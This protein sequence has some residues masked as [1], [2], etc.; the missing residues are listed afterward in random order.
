MVES[1]DRECHNRQPLREFFPAIKLPEIGVSEAKLA[2]SKGEVL[3]ELGADIAAHQIGLAYTRCCRR[4]IRDAR[5]L[6]HPPSLVSR[7]IDQATLTGVDWTHARGLD[8]AC[9]GELSL[10]PVARRIIDEL[11]NCSPRILVENI[12]TRLRGYELDPFGAWLSQVA[13]N[14]VYCQSH[15]KHKSSFQLS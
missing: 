15:A 9:G 6:L 11:P 3:A 12:A 4:N 10:A 1:F 7:L 2:E 14:A 5:C 13:L 8:P